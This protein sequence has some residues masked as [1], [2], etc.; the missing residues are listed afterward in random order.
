MKMISIKIM[1]SAFLLGLIYT[2]ALAQQVNETFIRNLDNSER[3]AVLRGDTVFL[4]KIW[5]PNMVVNTPANRVGT[6]E[7]TKM[8][9]RT[10]KIDYSSFERTI[11]KITIFENVAIVMGQEIVK[12]QRNSDNVGKTITRRFTNIWMNGNNGWSMVARQATVI[13]IL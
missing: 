1:I 6:V 2:S 13:S 12:P 8:L 7:S 3:E 4:F 11:E 9:T 10:G 5:S